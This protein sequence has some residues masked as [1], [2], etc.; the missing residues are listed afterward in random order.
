ML[1]ISRWTNM[2]GWTLWCVNRLLVLSRCPSESPRFELIE[3][4]T[5]S[6]GQVNNAGISI[7][8][9]QHGNRQRLHETDSSTWDKDMAIVCLAF[10]LLSYFHSLPFWRS[11]FACSSPKM[12]KP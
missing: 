6:L 3:K 7:E 10:H 2:E 11:I 9:T 8:A 4:L 12:A 5:K 1:S